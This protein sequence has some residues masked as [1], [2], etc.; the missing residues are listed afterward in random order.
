MLDKISRS[1]TLVK[2]SAAVLR[3]DKELLLFPVISSIATLLV[4]ALRSVR[5]GADLGSQGVEVLAG[6]RAGEW[7]ATDTL[8]ASQ[9]GAVPAAR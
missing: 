1:W 6:L 9:P 2:A 5:L 3:S 7:V 4:A 8:R